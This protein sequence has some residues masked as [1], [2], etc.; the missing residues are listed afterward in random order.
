VYSLRFG[1]IFSSQCR[2]Y[3]LFRIRFALEAPFMTGVFLLRTIGLI[4]VC[5]LIGCSGKRIGTANALLEAGDFIGARTMYEGVIACHPRDFTAH[6]GLAMSWC[7]EAIY[8]TEL[9]LADPDDWYPA[10]YQMTVAS[11]LDTNMQARRTLAIMHFNLGACYKKAGDREAAIS[12][13]QQAIDYDS[14]LLKAYNLL[15]A[16][17]HEQGDLDEAE[18]CYRRALIL[19]PDYA[20]AHFNLGAL[21]WARSD[22]VGAEKSFQNAAALEPDND[23]FQEW[24]TKAQAR[25]GRH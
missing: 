15:G 25:A 5:L 16:L 7:A 19:K 22:F 1:I 3:H 13:I 6:Y 21:D 8:K 24:L 11:H 20:M 9:G 10:I 12:R 4:C 14:T 17:Y 18:N 2:E 23:L